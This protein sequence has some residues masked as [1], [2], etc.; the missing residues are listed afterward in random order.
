MPWF[1]PVGRPARAISVT[2]PVFEQ[3]K[4]AEPV[5]IAGIYRARTAP[6]RSRDGGIFSLY[7]SNYYHNYLKNN[8]NILWEEFLVAL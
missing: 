6:V 8:I 7:I 3:A 4:I 1:P 5:E 2:T